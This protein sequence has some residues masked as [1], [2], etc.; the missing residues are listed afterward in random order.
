MKKF[1]H[2]F[3]KKEFSKI[4][5]DSLVLMKIKKL[6]KLYH[7]KKNYFID[8]IIIVIIVCTSN[9]GIID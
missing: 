9:K 4:S 5:K 6:R 7:L 1:V 2:G 3:Q 8:R